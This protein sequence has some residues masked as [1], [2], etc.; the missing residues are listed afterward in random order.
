MLQAKTENGNMITLAMYSLDKI[1]DLRQQIKFYCPICGEKVIPRA[2]PHT[3]PHFS[4]PKKASCVSISR[5]ES[6]YHEK[7]KKLLYQWLIQQEIDVT[8]ENYIPEIKRRSD[9]YVEINN[10]KIVIE[11]QCSRIPVQ[12][13]QQR[14]K[15]YQGIGIIPIWIL[16]AKQFR[17]TGRNQMKVDPFTLQFIH[18]FNPQTSYFLYFL[19]PES[20]QFIV[21]SDFYFI[22][23]SKVLASLNFLKLSTIKF[24]TLFQTQHLNQKELINDWRRE[25]FNFRTTLNNFRHGRDMSWYKWLYYQQTHIHYL[26]KEIYLPVKGHHLIKSSPWIWQSHICLDIIHPLKIGE[27]FS[28]N[29]CFHLLQSHFYLD[30]E[31]PLISFY[32]H[33]VEYYLRWLIKLLIIEKV[34]STS[35]KKIS[36]FKFFNHIEEAINADKKLIT[37]KK[38]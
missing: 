14:T 34:S 27:T 17:R 15:D 8:I 12:E 6:L 33:P 20:E 7:G 13:I 31:F 9:L 1:K 28:I 5:G 3:T 23:T 21:V 30:S 25:K 18:R 26:P 37:I 4:H 16:G 24:N 11:F 22:S 19:C 36:E 38:Y 10:K 32:I 29:R 2:G 35:Y